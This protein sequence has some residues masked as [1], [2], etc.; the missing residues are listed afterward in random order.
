MHS[1]VLFQL[2]SS[3]KALEGNL[4]MSPKVLRDV[5]YLGTWGPGPWKGPAIPAL[6][7]H[8]Q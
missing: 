4:P 6:Q 2:N 1:W 7:V 8:K 3:R 5:R